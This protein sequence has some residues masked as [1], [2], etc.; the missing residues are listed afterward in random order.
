MAASAAGPPPR[1]GVAAVI[2]NTEG[3]LLFGKRL[4]S[5]GAGTWQFPGGHLDYGEDYYACAARETLEETALRVRP[6]KLL[7]VTNSVWHDL[8]KHYITLFV[9]CEMETADAEPVVTEPEKCETWCWKEWREVREWAEH[10]D[11]A[12]PEWAD[13]KCFMP[14]VNLA[15]DQPQLDLGGQS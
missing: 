5:H 1:V 11:D 7:G 6:V 9:L 4:G 14:I 8:Q 2:R 10:D 13:K 12:A 3:K 15:R